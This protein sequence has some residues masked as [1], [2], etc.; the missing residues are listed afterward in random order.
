VSQSDHQVYA[1][2]SYPLGLDER[3]IIVGRRKVF[4]N[5]DQTFQ[6]DFN[7]LPFISIALKLIE[8]WGD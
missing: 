6:A 4:Q 8:I 1:F 3:P 5:I 2:H 7:E